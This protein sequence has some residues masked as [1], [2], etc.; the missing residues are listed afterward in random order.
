M[1]KIPDIAVKVVTLKDGNYTL[2]EL[3]REIEKRLE[4]SSRCGRLKIHERAIV[5]DMTGIKDV[6]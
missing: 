1:A 6:H 2:D 3:A 5:T 4:K